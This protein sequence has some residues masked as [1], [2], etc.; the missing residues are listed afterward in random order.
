M[1]W[2]H[3]TKPSRDR[4]QIFRQ[5]TVRSRRV[6]WGCDGLNS[7]RRFSETWR[8]LYLTA[9]QASGSAHEDDDEQERCGGFLHDVPQYSARSPAAP[10][11]RVK[12]TGEGVSQEKGETAQAQYK[13]G[14]TG[15]DEIW[16]VT[17]PHARPR[18]PRCG[19]RQS[20]AGDHAARSRPPTRPHSTGLG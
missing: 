15:R 11:G 13:V 6:V 2:V 20:R 1:V 5:R 17:R 18:G 12:S 9:R 7:G 16:R 19:R 10:P 14:S 3:G 8:L 4:L